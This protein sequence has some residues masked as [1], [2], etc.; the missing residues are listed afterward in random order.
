MAILPKGQ[1]W[2]NTCTAAIMAANARLQ[3]YAE[4]NSEWLHFLDLGDMFLTHQ[5]GRKLTW[6][7]IWKLYV[8]SESHHGARQC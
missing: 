2:P 5:V 3:A 1:A 7:S 8:P 4:K 6:K